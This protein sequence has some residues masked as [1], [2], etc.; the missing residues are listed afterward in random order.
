MRGNDRE[1]Q[2]QRIEDDWIGRIDN[3]GRVRRVR[4]KTPQAVDHFRVALQDLVL[5][6]AAVSG[7]PIRWGGLDIDVGTA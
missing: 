5:Y 7:T 2:R 4:P 6:R 1:L 3:P